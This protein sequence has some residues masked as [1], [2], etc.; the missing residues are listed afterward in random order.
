MK[1]LKLEAVIDDLGNLHIDVPT[2]LS[3]GAVDVVVVVNPSTIAQN[4]QKS[5]DFSDLA[6]R[7]RWQGNSVRMQ[8]KLRNEW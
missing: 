2:D 8:R 1:V 4:T 7:L 6:G 3:A 5:Y